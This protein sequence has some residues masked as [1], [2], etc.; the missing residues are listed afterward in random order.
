M[1]RHH[2]AN[3]SDSG[4]LAHWHRDFRLY[5]IQESRLPS[6]RLGLL[7]RLRGKG[8]TDITDAA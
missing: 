4:E 2:P 7:P 3:L 1:G 5:F 8:S 6:G